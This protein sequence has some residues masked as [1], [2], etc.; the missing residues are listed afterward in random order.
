[1]TGEVEGRT[2]E[3]IIKVMKEH[4]KEEAV[5]FIVRVVESPTK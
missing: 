1:M 2:V 3:C 4:L 5:V